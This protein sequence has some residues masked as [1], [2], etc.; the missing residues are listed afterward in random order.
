MKLI[1]PFCE[2]VV[3]SK[4]DQLFGS[5]LLCPQCRTIFNWIKADHLL[6]AVKTRRGK[7]QSTDQS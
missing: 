6:S 7:K 5:F 1:C 2:K 3:M 4:P